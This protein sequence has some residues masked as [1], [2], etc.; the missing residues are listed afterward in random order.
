MASKDFLLLTDMLYNKGW[1]IEQVVFEFGKETGEKTTAVLKKNDQ[2]QKFNLQSSAEDF[3]SFLVQ[4]QQTIDANGE[5]GLSKIRNNDTYW[6]DIDRLVDV[7]GGK[8]RAAM[9][10]IL[11][12]KFKFSFDPENG[13]RKILQDRIPTDDRDVRGVK[14]HFFETF[15]EVLIEARNMLKLKEIPE[16]SNSTFAGYASAYEQI[17]RHGFLGQADKTNV[18]AA[19]KKYLASVRVDHVAL[20]RRIHEQEKYVDFLR[21]L[22]VKAGHVEFQNGAHAILDAYWRLC[23]LCYPMLYVAQ[24]AV[25]F[26]EG[27]T[28]D[29]GPPSFED[30]VESLNNHPDTKKLVEC[31]EPILRNSEA[32][33]ASSIIMENGQPIVIAYETRGSPTQGDQ[34]FPIVRSD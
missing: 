20:M 23:E 15:A 6:N 4:F 13:I 2:T 8:T 22:L 34:T 30:L 31:V 5:G 21:Q 25:A 33:C 3:T 28:P 7:D 11:S 9:Q 26:A 16:K 14:D 32:H 18:I 24:A 27:R 29:S 12:G 10:S 17:L 1:I 19:Y